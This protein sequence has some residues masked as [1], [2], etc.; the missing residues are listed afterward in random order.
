MTS[1]RQLL[2]DAVSLL[3]SD[4]SEQLHYL[5]RLGVLPGVDE[6]V[7]EFDDIACARDDMLRTGELNADEHRMLAMLDVAMTKTMSSEDTMLW[8]PQA[9][10]HDERWQELR[11]RARDCQRTLSRM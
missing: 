2:I 6:L 8:T 1:R 11:I 5:E 7:L 4:A 9:V 3:A 10:M